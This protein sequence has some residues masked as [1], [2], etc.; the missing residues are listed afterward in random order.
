MSTLEAIIILAV[1]VAG[2]SRLPYGPKDSS[3]QSV[4]LRGINHGLQGC[5]WMFVAFFV[6]AYLIVTFGTK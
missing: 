3:E 4:A 5:L 2:I 6:V 1:I